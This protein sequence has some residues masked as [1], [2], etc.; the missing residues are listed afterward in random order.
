MPDTDVGAKEMAPSAR[1]IE[2]KIEPIAEKGKNHTPLPS[3]HVEARF[4][5]SEKAQQAWGL[6]NEY[7]RISKDIKGKDEIPD[8]AAAV[9]QRI[10]GEMAKLWTDPAVRKTIEIKLRESIQERKPYRGTLRRYRNLRTRLGELEGEHF[11][12]LRNQFLMRQMT[13]TLRGM[14]MA[15]VRAERKDVLDQIQS[16]ENDGEASEAV[17]REL[18]GVGR[19]NANVT[20][21]IAYERI[22]D[23]HSQFRETGII[24][25]PSRQALLEEVIEQTSK[26]TWMQLSGETGSGK[27][28]FAKQAS[29]VLNGEPPQYASGEKWGDA[30][31]L[32]GSKA[33]TPD[34]QVYYEFG[35]LVV[36]LT[37]CTNS[38]EMEE[39]IRKGV[40]GDGKLV[41]LDE[42]NKFD[43]DALFGVLKIASTLRPGE[44]F[45]FKELPG[46]K[47]RM[48]KKGF[49]I[50]ST[51]NPAT[52]R[53][54]RR[55]L[56]PAIDRLFYGG[57]KKVDYLPMDENEPELYEGFLAILM[58]D[59]GRIR[60]AEEELAPVYDEMTDEAKGLVYRKLS[61]D[62]ADHG[63]LY[64]F[65]RATSEI[66]K[67]FEQRENVAQTATDPGFLEK[68][69][70]DM[71][72]LVDW[73][74][75]YTTEVEGGL[76]LTS[77]LRQ[78]V[79]DFYTHIETEADHAIFRKI[80]THF[81]F[82]IERTPV[83]ISK[84]SYGPLTP[85]EMGYLTQKTQRPVTRIG[86]EI[87]PKT[88]IHIT[89][90]GREVEYLPVAASLEEGELTP[91]TFISFQDGL[92]QY[93]GV[94]PQT[95]EEVFVPV[96]SDEK[97]II[98]KQDFAEFKK[99]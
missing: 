50:I 19:E 47:L 8:D 17:K 32:I 87:V 60:V 94:N 85:L 9:M 93:L 2:R 64:R 39:A 98:I 18:G 57:K 3:S 30:T 79:H 21:L 5:P 44:T 99:N 33:I 81:G 11:D 84:P 65:A 20:A 90:D 28:T 72:V 77:Y 52:V 1:F 62:L 83:S 13:P 15:R 76:S 12:L 92:Y 75:G 61:S 49:A 63:T 88:K 34:G 73:M 24:M 51:M 45:G 89:P 96:A 7:A 78:K 22:R 69:V 4:Q 42:L 80:F 68:T 56:D 58:D 26:G 41:L 36:G 74:K 70:L 82:E 67:S 59:N 43:Q 25:T 91:N 97:E 54:E 40:E 95:N 66:H 6:Y 23:Y 16:L 31:K 14:D 27:T 37:G 71:E 10:E 38:I 29:Y 46:I 48:A 55:E 53:Y 86:E 35:P